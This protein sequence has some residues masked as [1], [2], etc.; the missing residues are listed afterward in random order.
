[1]YKYNTGIF[2]IIVF[3]LNT[4]VTNNY[5]FSIPVLCWSCVY[6]HSCGVVAETCEGSTLLL[7]NIVALDG[8]QS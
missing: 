6:E 7:K 3:V 2:G 8:N 4:P 1:M 5:W